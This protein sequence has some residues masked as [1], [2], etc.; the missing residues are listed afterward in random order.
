MIM[1]PL[2]GKRILVVEDEFLVAELLCA[3]LA[4]AGATLVAPTDRSSV[5]LD[6]IA[7]EALDGA[8]L[9]FMLAD[10][11]CLEVAQEL[12]SRGVPFLIVSALPVSELPA[13][14]RNSPYLGKPIHP[15][16]FIE[17]ATRTFNTPVAPPAAV[18]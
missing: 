5:A 12:G 6:Y 1:E 14:L 13:E 9:D 4:Q 2:A 15:A 10:G 17:L 7:N 3:R 16:V 11:T 18:A 8:V